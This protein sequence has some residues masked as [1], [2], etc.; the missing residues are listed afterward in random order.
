MARIKALGSRLAS[1]LA[2]LVALPAPRAEPVPV[3]VRASRRSGRGR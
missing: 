2:D 3:R 1:L